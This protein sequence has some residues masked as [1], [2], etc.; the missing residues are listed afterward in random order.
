MGKKDRQYDDDGLVIRTNK[1]EEKRKRE[2]IKT[3][4]KEQL[5]LL[6]NEKYAD[7]PIDNLLQAALIE[8]K[9]LTG[10][11]YQRHLS[12][13]AR[14]IHEQDFCT[15]RQ[16]VER[17]HHPY[18]NDPGKVRETEHYRDLLIAGDKDIINDLLGKFANVDI[19]YIRQ[20]ARNAAK[21]Q[22]RQIER[23]KTQAQDSE[24]PYQQPIRPTKSA[25]LLY[26]YLFKLELLA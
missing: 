10:S 13:V 21:E 18:R 15:I 20:L 19:Q 25:K 2:V 6:N 4:I 26:Q 7:L 14:L 3:F 16:A 24:Y 9:R 12:F 23:L 8:A 11:A 1:E 22:K 17:I 5:L